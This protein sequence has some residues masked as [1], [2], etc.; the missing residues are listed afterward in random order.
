MKLS[1]LGL[2]AVKGA[3]PGI[4]KKLAEALNRV[5]SVIYDYIASNDEMLT[6]AAALKVIREETGLSNDQIL[7]QEPVNEASGQK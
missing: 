6:M 7:E 3:R 2:L 1:H 4:I 5:D